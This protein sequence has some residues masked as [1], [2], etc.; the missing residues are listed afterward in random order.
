VTLA[1][2]ANPQPISPL[3]LGSQ[4][5]YFSTPVRERIRNEDLLK[6]WREMPVKCLRYPGGTWGDHYLWDNPSGSYF[7]VGDAN[8]IVTPK[9]FIENCRAIGAEPI[10]Q[11]NTNIRGSANG[12]HIN[13]GKVEDIR[14]GADRAARWVREANL[15]NGWGVKYWE[16]GNEVW[17]WMHPEEYAVF[18]VEYS[19]AMKAVDPSIKIIACGLTGKAGPFSATWLKFPDDPNWKP[20]VDMINNAEEWNAALITGAA[21][22]FDYIAPHIYLESGDDEKSALERYNITNAKILQNERLS[23][24]L[25]WLPKM[26]SGVKIAVTE[27][28]C[29]FRQSVPVRKDVTRELYYYSLGN[30]LNTGLFF[31]KMVEASEEIPIAVLHSL[32]DIQTLWY[33]PKKEMAKGEPLPHPSFLAMEI[34]GHHLGTSSLESKSTGLPEMTLEGKNYPSVYVFASEDAQA[35]YFVAINL[36]PDHSR[37]LRLGSDP[38]LNLTAAAVCT[39]MTGESLSTENFKAWDR[40]IPLPV[41]LTESR[42]SA[43]DGVFNLAMPPHSMVG[44]SIPKKNK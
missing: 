41:A 26:G 7:A 5:N 32:D 8:S 30:G 35:A 22:S 37:D 12:D 15:K 10:F 16:I 40:S 44:V 11:V 18:V 42:V 2:G 31:G 4:Y 20:R 27:W 39:W 28:G 23:K 38:K 3:L 1:R 19:K 36:D 25:E 17:I 9:Q 33:W 6:S 21:G 13:P 34:W 24:Q 14:L 29:N 43:V